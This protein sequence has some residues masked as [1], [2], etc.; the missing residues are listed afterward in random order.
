MFAQMRQHIADLD[1]K[2]KAVSEKRIEP[3]KVNLVSQHLAAISGP[4]HT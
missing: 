4:F 3:H 1:A 2:I